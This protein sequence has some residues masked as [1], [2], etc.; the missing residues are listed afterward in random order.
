[1]I[2]SDTK[3]GPEQIDGH[4]FGR[5]TY[6]L[7]GPLPVA[8]R[9]DLLQY[10]GVVHDAFVAAHANACGVARSLIF[11]SEPAAGPANMLRRYSEVNFWYRQIIGAAESSNPVLAKRLNGPMVRT[12][13]EDIGI[14]EPESG[15]FGRRNFKYPLGQPWNYAG[16]RILRDVS[17]IPGKSDVEKVQIANCLIEDATRGTNFPVEFII[18]LAREA[19]SK[20]M[21]KTTILK[22]IFA[23]GR[24]AEE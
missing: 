14:H 3:Y 7:V 10:S 6:Y 12:G 8:E 18:H 11:S 5:G 2:D 1:M 4:G 17:K 23:A 21:S 20:G 24:L 22:H 9:M 13:G 15:P 19:A 16:A